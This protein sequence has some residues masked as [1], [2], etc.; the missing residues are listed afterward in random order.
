MI[1]LYTVL[2]KPDAE[3]H[4]PNLSLGGYVSQTLHQNGVK[5]NIFSDDTQKRLLAGT[6]QTRM[7]VLQNTTGGQVTGVKLFTTSTSDIYTYKLIAVAPALD[8]SCNRFYFEHLHN[9]SGLPL[10]GTPVEYP[11]IGSSLLVG[12][13]EDQEYIGIWIIR[14]VKQSYI[15]DN[16]APLVGGDNNQDVS[17]DQIEFIKNKGSVLLPT[18]D[19]FS[20]DIDWD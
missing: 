2:E 20:L 4:S 16:L 19:N 10:Q 11:S 3:Q 14:E 12:T 7:A 1:L 15:D 9:D 8:T 6:R 13:M 18:V 5:N 17:E